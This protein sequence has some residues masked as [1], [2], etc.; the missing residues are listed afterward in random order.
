MPAGAFR[1]AVA[2]ALLFAAIASGQ[3]ADLPNG[4]TDM[5]FGRLLF[6]AGR[7]RDARAF[8]E[9]ARPVDEEE[10][11]EREFLLGRLDL[12]QGRPRAAAARF[13]A[14]LA[15]RPDLTRVRLELATAYYAA[16]RDDKARFHFERSMADRLPSSVETEVERFL[17]RIDNR[18][19]WSASLSLA[20]APESNPAKRTREETVR[21]GGAPFRLDEDSREASGTGVMLS[22]GASF[23]PAIGEGQ[24]GVL[25]ASGSTKRYRESAW[26]DLSVAVEAGAARLFDRASLS[27]GLRAGRRWLGNDGYSRSLGP[28][29]RGNARLSA[30]TRLEVSVDM[31]RFSHDS[32]PDLDGWRWTARPGLVHALSSR[33]SLEAGLD[34]ERAS[35]RMGRH[36]SRMAGASLSFTHAFRGGLSVTPGLAVHRRRHEGRD[37]LFGKVR[38]DT[39]VRP[40]LRLLHRA[41]RHR[42]FAPWIGYSYERNRSSIAIHSYRNHALMIGLSKMF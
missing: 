10:A 29:L 17:D 35:A 30:A 39:T 11:L 12:R 24:R 41:L 40:S 22:G 21:I 20:L 23:T 32:R 7:L 33:T 16:E 6:D 31:L 37:P 2:A 9:Q 15:R 18:K 25:A 34:L 19:R 5:Q 27:G 13:E 36:G 14:L 26:N 4:F 1:A 42:G 8:L 38:E 3:A 28:W